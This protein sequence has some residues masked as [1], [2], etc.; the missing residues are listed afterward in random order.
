MSEPLP[1]RVQGHNLTT[2]ELENQG[3]PLHRHLLEVWV[4]E[5]FPRNR[6][7]EPVLQRLVFDK[8][9]LAHILTQLLL[10]DLPEIS[11]QPPSVA[12]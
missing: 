5:L 8:T 10:L 3:G 4:T 9:Q 6:L 11:D 1:V 12:Q 7:I 2:I